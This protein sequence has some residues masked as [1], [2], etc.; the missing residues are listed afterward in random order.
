M[1]FGFCD[2]ND[3]ICV[4]FLRYSN[5]IYLSE[6]SQEARAHRRP[7][8][9]IFILSIIYINR[10]TEQLCSFIIS[11]DSKFPVFFC[12]FLSLSL[13][14]LI[15]LLGSLSLSLCIVSVYCSRMKHDAH[16]HMLITNAVINAVNPKFKSDL[17]FITYTRRPEFQPH[18]APSCTSLYT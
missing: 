18:G 2:S 5:Q 3:C 17:L 8:N 12:I 7:Q 1:E 9:H 14:L 10:Y 6:R 4:C 16:K 11:S 15:F 13:S